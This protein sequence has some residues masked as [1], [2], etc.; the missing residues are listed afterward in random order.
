MCVCVCGEIVLFGTATCVVQTY[1][2][3]KLHQL[4]PNQ[5]VLHLAITGQF[6][7]L[8]GQ[9]KHCC[10]WQVSLRSG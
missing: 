9:C 1:N 7:D 8:S 3:R 2:S 5:L 4:K 10:V 6:R